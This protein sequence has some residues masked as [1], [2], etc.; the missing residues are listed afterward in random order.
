MCVRIYQA[1][2]EAAV[3][4]ADGAVLAVDATAAALRVVVLEA[5]A[6]DRDR[7]PAREAGAGVGGVETQQRAAC[8]ERTA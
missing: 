8:E 2:A 5:A 3:A 1:V 6:Q 7:P 4:D